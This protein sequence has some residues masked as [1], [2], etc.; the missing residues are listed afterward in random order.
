[1][2]NTRHIQRLVKLL[3]KI[4][5]FPAMDRYF[6]KIFGREIKY[7]WKIFRH[8]AAFAQEGPEWE[9]DNDDQIAYFG[10]TRVPKFAVFSTILLHE[11]THG[12]CFFLGKP[13]RSRMYPNGVHEEKVCWDI[14]RMICRK[15]C[16]EYER[17]LAALAYKIGQL[18]ESGEIEKAIKLAEKLPKFISRPSDLV[19]PS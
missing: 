15:L 8:I 18:R 9:W 14:S 2:K 12:M 5:D 7:S 16:I 11:C 4:E 19:K 6:S 10:E 3:F 13:N 17:E 1:M